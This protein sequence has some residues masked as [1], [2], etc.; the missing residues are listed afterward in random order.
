[1]G[2]A[3][4]LDSVEIRWPSGYVDRHAELK[5]DRQ[6]NL[7]EGQPPVMVRRFMEPSAE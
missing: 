4:R 3:T 2:D 5:V 7:R 1:M 6:Y